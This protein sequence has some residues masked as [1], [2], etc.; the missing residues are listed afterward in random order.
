MIKRPPGPKGMPLIGSLF[1]FMKDRLGFLKMVREEF[2]DFAYFK[3][4]PRHIYF[5]NNPEFIENIL[6]KDNRKFIKSKVLQ[7]A[8]IIV[9]EGLLTSE[10]EKHLKNRRAIQPLFHN[11][12][13]PSYADIMVRETRELTEKWSGGNTIDLHNEMMK[14]TQTIVVK[15][16]FGT[17]LGG[18]T[19][20]LVKSLNYIMG[21]FPKIM[22]PFSELL[23]YLPIPSMNR[24]RKEMKFLDRTIYN[25]VNERRKT[26]DEKNDLLN[27]LLNTRD[28]E[29]NEFFSD[30][31]IRDEIITFFIA[32]QETTSNSLCWTYY[33]LSQNPEYEE[34]L[35][36]EIDKVPGER[37]PTIDNINQLGIAENIFREALRMYPPA[38]V[39]ARR[40]TEDYEINGYTI[41]A[42]SDIYM[43]QY[44]VHHDSRFFEYPYKFR[45]DRWDAESKLPRFA[46]FP[47]GGGPRR[48]IG[49]PFAYM[50]AVLIIAVISRKWKLELQPDFRV[51]MEP[52]ITIRP[53]YGMKMV[54]KNRFKH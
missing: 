54:L 39:V 35:L 48:C 33:L 1:D 51:E 20:E 29:G 8:K 53:K 24:L 4:G 6:V 2:G 23:D 25:L 21:M 30:K 43:S 16:L 15:T 26:G 9:G 37:P 13:I 31:Q 3:L 32:G 10:K 34:L 41:P 45:P 7:R 52:F 46:Y 44:V 12:A 50:E 14:L 22:M 38:W 42:N 18:K 28:E 27:V 17:E 47:F 49:E 11:K 36:K 5:I 19:Q 40:A